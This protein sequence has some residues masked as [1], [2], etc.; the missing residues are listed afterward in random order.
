MSAHRGRLPFVPLLLA[1]VAL[2][3]CGSGEREFTPEE[4]IQTINAEGAGLALGPA[5]AADDGGVEVHSVTFTEA[6]TGVGSP[7]IDSPKAAHGSGRLLIAGDAD[8]ARIEF[9]RC[10]GVDQLTCFRA[11]NA[12]LSFKGMDGADQA[13]IVTSLEAIQTAGG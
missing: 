1:W 5:I 4:F 9:E 7:A 2:G 13:R 3:G 11:A 10:E 6:S 8:A 12:V